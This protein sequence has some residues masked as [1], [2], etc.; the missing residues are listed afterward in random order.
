MSIYFKEKLED[1]LFALA[2][3]PS[4]SQYAKGFSDGR[5]TVTKYTATELEINSDSSDSEEES[6]AKQLKKPTVKLETLWTTKRHKSS[7]RAIAYDQTGEYIFTLGLDQ[8]LKKASAQNGHVVKKTKLPAAP[9][10]CALNEKLI[11]VGD[12]QSGV[13]TYDLE[14]LEMVSRIEPLV[15]SGFVSS[16]VPLEAQR[17]FVVSVDS[18]LVVLDVRDGKVL[19]ES[20]DQEDEILCG[21][22]TEGTGVFGMSEGVMTIWNKYFEDQQNRVLLGKETVDCILIGEDDKTVYAGCGDGTVREVDLEKTKVVGKF[23][24]SKDSVEK[25]DADY[26]WRLVTANMDMIKVWKKKD[27]I[28]ED[29][30]KES[31]DED[32]KK[33][34]RR[35]TKSKAKKLA[36]L[37]HVPIKGITAFDDL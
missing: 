37:D 29:S 13:T 17:K 22:Y 19:K 12:D 35:R 21:A 30:D 31:E 4:K 15:E 16:V 10:C 33:R 24:H 5:V 8:V 14:S 11:V 3:H 2:F 1:P 9:S 6:K 28:E 7:C 18:K 25:V 20:E 23:Q 32:Q 34:K 26:E 27:E 36:K